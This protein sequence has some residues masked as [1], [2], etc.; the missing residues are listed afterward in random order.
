MRWFRH[1]L[2]A[3]SEDT[4]ECCVHSSRAASTDLAPVWPVE[5]K[6]V[7]APKH[8]WPSILGISVHV[9]LHLAMCLRYGGALGC[10][11]STLLCRPAPPSEGH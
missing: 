1:G 4:S 7:A 2:E 3:S 9:L 6:D 8:P 11:A 10:A 5:Q